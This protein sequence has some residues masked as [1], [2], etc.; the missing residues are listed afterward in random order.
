M[1]LGTSDPYKATQ[2]NALLLAHNSLS[3]SIEESVVYTELIV[4]T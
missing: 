3:L 2:C 4:I 1:G